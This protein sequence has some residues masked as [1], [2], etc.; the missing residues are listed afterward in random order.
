MPTSETCDPWA[1]NATRTET[2]LCGWPL[3]PCARR[4]VWKGSPG[5]SPGSGWGG[6]TVDWPESLSFG[7]DLGRELPDR[8]WP[9]PVRAALGVT[10]HWLHR[11][12]CS[13]CGQQEAQS[14]LGGDHTLSC[15]GG[16]SRPSFQVHRG[17]AR[18]WGHGRRPGRKRRGGGPSQ[19]AAT[20]T[21]RPEQSPLVPPPWR[22]AG[23]LPEALSPKPGSS[24]A[25]TVSFKTSRFNDPK[26]RN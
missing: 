9:C 13:G 11:A 1:A 5:G 20:P 25:S 18:D 26:N 19:H 7:I 16:P 4:R 2:C 17:H 21:G 8:M 23:H 12:S 14:T 3:P 6:K 24:P 15:P 10:G 22:D